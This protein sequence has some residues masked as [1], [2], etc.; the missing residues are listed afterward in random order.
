MIAVTLWQQ[1]EC[2]YYYYNIYNYIIIVLDHAIVYLALNVTA[3]PIILGA[4]SIYSVNAIWQQFEHYYYYRRSGNFRC[5]KNFVVAPNHENLTHE[6][7]LTTNI[8]SNLSH[9]RTS[10]TAADQMCR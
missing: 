9:N 5:Q 7:F 1:F 3:P 4:W 2:Y 10:P 8:N 6:I